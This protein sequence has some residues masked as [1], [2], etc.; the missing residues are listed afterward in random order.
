MAFNNYLE[1]L[2]DD[3][4]PPCAAWHYWGEL[5]NNQYLTVMRKY[6]HKPSIFLRNIKT[7]E[8]HAALLPGGM[9]GLEPTDAQRRQAFPRAFPPEAI[10]WL[11]EIDGNGTHDRATMTREA[12]ANRLDAHYWHEVIDAKKRLKDG[13]RGGEG[14]ADTRKRKQVHFE[15]NQQD[16]IDDSPDKSSKKPSAPKENKHKQPWELPCIFHPGTDCTFDK[17]PC[18]AHPRNKKFNLDEALKVLGSPTCP[19]WY[20]K[21]CRKFNVRPQQQQQQQQQQLQQQQFQFSLPQNMPTVPL[22]STLQIVPPATQP[23]VPSQTQ[24]TSFAFGRQQQTAPATTQQ[25]SGGGRWVLNPQG[26]WQL[27]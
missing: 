2:G 6:G 24:G 5:Q 22:G 13:R 25:A 7:F 12:M 16:N 20:K 4:N 23:A 3:K 27:A 21:H 10:H 19:A 18:N 17:C 9:A 14:E 8:T 11:F 1:E 26:V 15:D